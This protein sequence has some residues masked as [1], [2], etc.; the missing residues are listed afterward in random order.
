MT[1]PT[2]APDELSELDEWMRH[3]QQFATPERDPRARRAWRIVL[4]VVASFVILTLAA[5]GGYVVWA[6]NTPVRLPAMVSQAPA[7][8]TSPAAV[9]AMPS[10]GSAA[11]RVEG[12]ESYLG[13]DASGIWAGSGSE[14][15]RPIASISKLITAL[16]VLDAHPL[17][18]DESGP[19]LTFSEADEDLYDAYYVQGATIAR[20][21][22][23]SSM[24]LRDALSTMLIPSASNYAEAVST[25]AFGS[26]GG[27]VSAARRWLTANGMNDT[28]I[29][30]P[31]G[32]DPRNASTPSD[33]ITL[34]AIAAANPVV[35]QISATRS[36]TVPGAG[37]IV[38]T[39]DLLGTSGI[40]GLK[41]GNLGE[42]EHNL[43]YTA[44]LDAGIGSPL[45]ITG[46]ALGGFSH[47][48]VNA[49]VVAL[50]DS[51][52]AGFHEL[53]LAEAGQDVGSLSTPWGSSARIVIGESASILTWSDTPVT[54][55]MS[56]S[57]PTA[58]TDGEQ[59]GTITWTAGPNTASAPVVIEGDIEPPTEWWRLTHPGE[60]G[61]DAR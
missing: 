30:E 52:R 41:T 42:G 18:P 12:A 32:L 25:W 17:G 59:I 4:I 50:L 34:G 11:I 55:E 38:N 13:P 19:T 5:G 33:L 15:A 31:T 1:T 20:M 7:V 36:M 21:P 45:S 27:F 24:S 46:V 10:E 6:L 43:L 26:Q 60:L 56:V 3:E 29:V 22:A 28:T 61:D 57:T 14:D 16:V 49:E 37:V 9:L 35:A 48:T 23:G 54:V 2:G 8:P 47:G 58:Y 51:I 53:P 39:N 44:T 40:S